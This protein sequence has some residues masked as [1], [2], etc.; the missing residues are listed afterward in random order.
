MPS[1]SKRNLLVFVKVAVTADAVPAKAATARA[2]AVNNISNKG[3]MAANGVNE[4]LYL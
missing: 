1:E 2:T 4:C 3:L